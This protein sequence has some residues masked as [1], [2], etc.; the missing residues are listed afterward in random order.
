MAKICTGYLFLGVLLT[1]TTVSLAFYNKWNNI[2]VL[3]E[4]EK[5]V[6]VWSRQQ[7]N[8]TTIILGDSQVKDVKV[9][10]KTESGDH[11]SF[12]RRMASNELKENLFVVFPLEDD[13]LKYRDKILVTLLR[14]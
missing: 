11:I 1:L 12:R 5:E 8:R 10:Q 13:M 2:Y 3:D 14:K 6:I 4:C 7:K 9:Y